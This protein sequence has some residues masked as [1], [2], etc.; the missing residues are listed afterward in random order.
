M[1]YINEDLYACDF[2][3]VEIKWD[4]KDDVHGEIWGCEECGS[5]FCSKCLK[6]AV[7]ESGYWKIIR[8]YDRILCPTCAKKHYIEEKGVNHEQ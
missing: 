2:C 4:G 6:D 8:E 7:G 1:A 3:G 5:T